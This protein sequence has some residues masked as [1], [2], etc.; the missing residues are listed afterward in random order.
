MNE[1]PQAYFAVVDQ[2]TAALG[3]VRRG[4]L[5]A[6]SVAKPRA[7]PALAAPLAIETGLDVEER[8]RIERSGILSAAADV[9]DRG[10]HAEDHR[11]RHQ[12][13]V[14]PALTTL[15]HGSTS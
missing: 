14:P 8:V 1:R 4:R 12:D 9:A 5:V 2:G 7:K 15:A 13:R 3:E 10:A 11:Q 6:G